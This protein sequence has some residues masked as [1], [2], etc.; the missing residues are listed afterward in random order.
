MKHRSRKN[1]QVWDAWRAVAVVV[2]IVVCSGCATPGD[3]ERESLQEE[4]PA[5]SPD[6]ATAEKTVVVEGRLTLPEAI[7]LTLAHH[8][9]IQT[10]HREVAVARGRIVESYGLALPHI[11]A[12]ATYTRWDEA[13][14]VAFGERYVPMGL[15]TSASAALTLRQPIFHGGAIAATWR[16]ARR[17]AALAEAMRQAVTQQ[18]IFETV[19]QYYDALLAQHL[20]QVAEEALAAAEAH[21]DDVQRR[22]ANGLASEYDVLRAEVEVANRRTERI[23][24]QHA[25][26]LGLMRLVKAMGVSQRSRLVPDGELAYRPLTPTQDEALRLARSRRPDLAQARCTRAL[27]RESLRLAQ[28]AYWP[29][30][31]AFCT[32]KWAKPDPHSPTRDEWGDAWTL[33]A[34]LSWPLWTSGAR[35]GRIQQEAARVEQAEIQTRDMEEAVALDVQQAILSLHEAEDL[36]ASQRWNVRRAEE[37]LRLAQTGYQQGVQSELEVTD[38]NAALTRTRCL[39]YQALHAHAVA[40][41]NYLRAV[42]ILVPEAEEVSGKPPTADRAAGPAAETRPDLPNPPRLSEPTRSASENDRQG[43]AP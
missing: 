42:G 20:L 10:A 34:M 4:M 16:M 7:R 32:Q 12:D 40:R 37:A 28:S 14:S 11:V 19:R 15:D 31:D 23:R 43:E 24:Q 26:T 5:S 17:Q 18:A 35:L 29:H 30:L 13:P 2:G 27:R 36:L 39:Y 1:R 3:T 41:L 33:G 25:L 21:R 22:R 38:A 6:A 8:K 9:G